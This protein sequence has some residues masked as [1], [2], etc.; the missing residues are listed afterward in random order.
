MRKILTLVPVIAVLAACSS[1]PKDPY[2]RRAYEERERREQAVE[3][4]LDKAPKWMT[5]L[6]SSANAV[7]ANGTAVS[8]DFSMADFKAKM[9]AFG[10]ICI[11]AGGTV[12]QQ[13]KIFMQDSGDA[14]YETS[15]MAIKTMCPNV[16]VTGAEI[17]EIKRIS[18]GARYRTYVL[19]ALPTGDANLLQKRKDQLRLQNRADGRSAA[20]FREMDATGKPAQ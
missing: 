19:V 5:E 3:R 2:E 15:E 13:G 20:A 14:S 8:G 10:K 11:A 1:A 12:S 9:V 6:P 4:S 7:Y 16:D 18:E 17:K